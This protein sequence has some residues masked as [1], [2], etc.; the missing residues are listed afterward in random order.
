MRG[1]GWGASPLG[2]YENLWSGVSGRRTG[3]SACER[4]QCSELAK[5]EGATWIRV[6]HGPMHR[7]VCGMGPCTDPSVC[8]MGPCTDPCVA[9]DHAQIR[10]WHATMHRSVCGMGP[11][12]D[13]LRAVSGLSM[14][15]WTDPSPYIK[16]APTNASS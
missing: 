14:V 3:G 10:V 16:H 9:C 1:R 5:I 4:C 6:W 13:P 2:V 12:T 15:R 7:S 11:C 8:G